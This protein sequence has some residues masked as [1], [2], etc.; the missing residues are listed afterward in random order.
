MLSYF[1]E[2][3]NK[4]TNLKPFYQSGDN[5]TFWWFWLDTPGLGLCKEG[6]R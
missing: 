5:E 1:V 3:Y 4:N 2:V 6:V